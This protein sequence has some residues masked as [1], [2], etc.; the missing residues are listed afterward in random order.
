MEDYFGIFKKMDQI[1][2][3]IDELELRQYDSEFNMRLNTMLDNG[4]L[5]IIDFDEVGKPIF[6]L[7]VSVS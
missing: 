7:L 1:N 3:F 6:K 4:E 2:E 5:A